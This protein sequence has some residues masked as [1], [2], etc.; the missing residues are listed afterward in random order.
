M[1]NISIRVANE[2][3]AEALREIYAYYV[4][5]TAIT[6]E[7]TVPSVDEFR[8]RICEV[9]SKYPYL[10][11]ERD[12]KIVGYAY[13]NS[14]NWREAYSW[15]VETTV[16]VQKDNKGL[17][18]GKAL[19]NVLEKVLSFQNIINLNACIGYPIKEDEY[20][21]K[22]SAIF[23]EHLGY[24]LAGE[25]YK[26]GY[27]FNKWYNMVWMEKHIGKHIDKPMPIKRFDEI[28][29]ELFDGKKSYFL[30]F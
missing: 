15:A 23:H 27:K 3:D 4:I 30:G 10:V 26:C 16:Y 1:K 29:G 5:N 18:I 7:Y 28:K 14:F 24:R 19:Y 25:F 11:A 20:L 17:G 21:T 12:G 6:F 8:N 13:A 9:L 2:E 22:N